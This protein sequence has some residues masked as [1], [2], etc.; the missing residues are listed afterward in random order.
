M[1]L[2]VPFVS[3]ARGKML[4]AKVT[5]VWLPSCVDPPVFVQATG[6]GEWL[7]TGGAGEGLVSR[8]RPLV[9]LQ[10][11]ILRGSLVTLGAGIRFLPGVD[12]HVSPQ[13]V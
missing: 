4:M 13:P 8:V 7:V 1:H 2:E 10:V 5:L 6:Q 9:T 3:Q 11:T 12:S